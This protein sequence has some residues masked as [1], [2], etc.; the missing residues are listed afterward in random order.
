MKKSL[1]TTRVNS[2]RTSL[3]KYIVRIF[4]SGIVILLLVF[5]TPKIV[6][7]VSS[8]LLWPFHKIELWFTE[9][10]TGLPYFI[11]DRQDLINEISELKYEIGF[12]SDSRVEEEL[13]RK[14]NEELKSLLGEELR[15][16]TQRATV[17]G[18]PNLIP[19]DVLIIDKGSEDGI[20]P[21]AP[22]YSSS[23]TVIGI[24]ERV[25]KNTSVVQLTTSPAFKSTVYVYGPNIYTT[26]VG[27]GGGVL[28]VGVPQGVNLEI[29]NLVVLPS[30]E[31]GLFGEISVIE[32][33]PADPEQY[34][35]VSLEIPINSIHFVAVGNKPIPEVDFAAAQANVEKIR[36]DVFIVPVPKDILVDL[37]GTSSATSTDTN[38]TTTNSNEI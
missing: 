23:R 1:L 21:N 18:R 32:S 20:Q 29:G 36:N 8:V 3:N 24:V 17:I 27:V 16:D 30:L 14:E 10:K 34:G 9:A 12:D 31:A 28:R 25:S 13:L 26:A 7:N 15:E 22:V 2:R 19:Y 5:F 35:F 4:L 6:A 11:R 33:L 38:A 37:N